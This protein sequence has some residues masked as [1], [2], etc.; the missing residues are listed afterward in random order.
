MTPENDILSTIALI[1]R[2]RV[3]PLFNTG[4]TNNRSN[5]DP[6]MR[7]Y[8]NMKK[9]EPPSPP[10]FE[11]N[12]LRFDANNP[13]RK[14]RNCREYRANDDYETPRHKNCLFCK[15]RRVMRSLP[16]RVKRLEAERKASGTPAI[17]TTRE[18]RAKYQR[19]R[20][21]EKRGQKEN[22]GPRLTARMC[23]QCRVYKPITEFLTDWTRRC[24]ICDGPDSWAMRW[25][26]PQR[27]R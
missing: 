8:H 25:R 20:Y 12:T 19:D 17:T 1:W 11:T 23:R 27:V 2:C 21:R 26:N 3:V 18:G 6:D 14:C 4:V 9:P 5:P 22:T 13:G 10:P 15:E 24:L 16:G 7:I